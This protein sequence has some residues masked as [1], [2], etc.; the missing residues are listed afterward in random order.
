MIRP[1]SA[2]GAGTVG[3]VPA[4]DLGGHDVCAFD[5]GIPIGAAALALQYGRRAAAAAST[6]TGSAFAVDDRAVLAHLLLP[7]VVGDPV[8]PAPP[9]RV[10]GGGHV[11]A[12]VAAGDER[13]LSALVASEPGADAERVSALAQGCWLPVTPYRPPAGGAFVRRRTPIR[14]STNKRDDSTLTPSDVVVVDMTAMWAGPLCTMLLAEW[15]ATVVTV[16][17]DARR[18]GL[19]RS[20]AQFAVLDGGKARRPWD[21]HRPADRRAFEDLLATADVLVDSFSDRV[22]PNLGYGTAALAAINPELVHLAIRAFPTGTPE[23]SWVAYG[24]GVHAALGLGLVDGVPQPAL[25][26]YPD[27]LA[28]LLA[29]AEVLAVLALPGP[30]RPT[31]DVSLATAAAPL[32]ATAGGHPI[33][34]FDEGALSWLRDVTGGRPGPVL[35]PRRGRAPRPRDRWDGGR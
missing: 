12:D 1:C 20:P 28:G 10:P 22:L 23:G 26:A 17:P 14:A 4:R 21:L 3:S 8:V 16:E 19:R 35:V 6:L 24:R 2:S 27:P 11:H 25:L 9:R 18:D 32:V 34:V 31:V 15:G 33:G 13:L 5:A 7:L 29:C 30:E